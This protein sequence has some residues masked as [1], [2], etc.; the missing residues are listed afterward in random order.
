MPG[1]QECLTEEGKCAGAEQEAGMQA[2]GPKTGLQRAPPI[3]VRFSRGSRQD[4][5]QRLQQEFEKPAQD[6]GDYRANSCSCSVPSISAVFKVRA[7][8]SC[9]RCR[10]SSLIVCASNASWDWLSMDLVE[11]TPCAW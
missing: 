8:S 2:E 11:S 3:T 4:V 6:R 9:C 5:A 10:S 1:K 7:L